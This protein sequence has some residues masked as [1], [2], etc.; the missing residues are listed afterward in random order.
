MAEP[1]AR[2]RKRRATRARRGVTTRRSNQW[3]LVHLHHRVL[4]HPYLLVIAA[5][6]DRARRHQ[7]EVVLIETRHL[8]R[9]DANATVVMLIAVRGT[10][11]AVTRVMTATIPGAGVMRACNRLT[12][13]MIAGMTVS[14]GG[15]GRRATTASSRQSAAKTQLHQHAKE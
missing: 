14:P 2:I 7:A 9:M 6:S 3:R 12:E 11:L 10:F 5:Q 1:A 13:V 15:L 8:E 4:R